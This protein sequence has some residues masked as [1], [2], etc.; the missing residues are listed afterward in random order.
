MGRWFQ[1]E[2]AGDRYIFDSVQNPVVLGCPQGAPVF[3]IEGENELR[4]EWVC[5]SHNVA[6]DQIDAAIKKIDALTAE[7]DELQRRLDIHGGAR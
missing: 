6:I 5:M 3:V 1:E 2:V 7:L 4:A